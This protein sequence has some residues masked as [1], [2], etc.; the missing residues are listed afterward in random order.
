[1]SMLFEQIQKTRPPKVSEVTGSATGKALAGIDQLLVVLPT[2]V[3]AAAWNRL[4]Q[5]KK[6]QALM[7]RRTPGSVPA[8]KTRLNNKRQTAVYVG[9]V[10]GSAEAFETLTF[11]TKM[12]SALS[13]EKAGVLGNICVRFDDHRREPRTAQIV[14]PLQAAA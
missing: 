2:R 4:P 8:V 7:R 11:A 5:G 9:N 3:P 13:G 6:V 1:M 10:D 12:V 14:Y